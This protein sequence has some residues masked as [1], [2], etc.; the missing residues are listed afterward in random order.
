MKYKLNVGEDE[1]YFL[2]LWLTPNYIWFDFIL[3][4]L[5]RFYFILFDSVFDEFY[6]IDLFFLFN[7][8][9]YL[10]WLTIVSHLILTLIFSF[11]FHFIFNL[12]DYYIT[13]DTYSNINKFDFLLFRNIPIEFIFIFLWC[14]QIFSFHIKNLRVRAYV[15]IIMRKILSDILLWIWTLLNKNTMMTYRCTHG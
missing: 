15:I 2:F 13:L 14:D 5:I 11:Q 10:I 1:F 9:S 6:S 8:I 4:V 7:F 12:V 3:F